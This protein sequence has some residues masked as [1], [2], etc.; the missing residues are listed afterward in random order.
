ML[1]WLKTSPYH[2]LTIW[3][4]SGG[5]TTLRFFFGSYPTTFPA[6]LQAWQPP[7]R[8]V[9]RAAQKSPRWTKEF[10]QLRGRGRTSPWRRWGIPKSPIVTIGFNAKLLVI[11]DDW[12]TGAGGTPKWLWTFLFLLMCLEMC[13]F[14]A[15]GVQI[16]HGSS[17]CIECP[18]LHLHPSTALGPLA[19]IEL[20]PAA[21]FGCRMLTHHGLIVEDH[22]NGFSWFS[23]SLEWKLDTHD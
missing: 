10:H 12:M 11:H 4:L 20:H 15:W 22:W 18:K 9:M 5:H 2:K 8:Q 7:R 17:G 3:H 16:Q 21:R 13:F 6:C 23:K 1:W 19:P 14:S